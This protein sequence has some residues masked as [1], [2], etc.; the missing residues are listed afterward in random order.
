[1]LQ[2]VFEDISKN[3]CNIYEQVS[4]FLAYSRVSYKYVVY[5][6]ASRYEIVC[7]FFYYI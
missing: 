7:F 4:D 1:M 3:K 6:R 5:T 2:I